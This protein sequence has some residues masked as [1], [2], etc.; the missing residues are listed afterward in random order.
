MGGWGDAGGR[1]LWV[2]GGVGGGG[3]SAGKRVLAL[4]S[5]LV[6]FLERR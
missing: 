6:V 4:V 1:M 2:V 3:G 5:V